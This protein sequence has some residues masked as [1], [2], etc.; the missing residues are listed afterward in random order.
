[1]EI[2]GEELTFSPRD[3]QENRADMNQN[4]APSAHRHE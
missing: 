2:Q 3:Q 4:P 1:M